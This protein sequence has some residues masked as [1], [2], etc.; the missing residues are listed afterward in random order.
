[1]AGE[2]KDTRGTFV[3][4]IGVFLKIGAGGNER[5]VVGRVERLFVVVLFL[6]RSS[7]SRRFSS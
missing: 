6:S 3:L 7:C 2:V 5:A 1:M 4:G